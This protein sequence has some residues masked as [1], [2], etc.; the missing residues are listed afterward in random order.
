M[1]AKFQRGDKVVVKVLGN[2]IGMVDGTARAQ[3][4]RSF[5][6]VSLD[7]AKLSSYYPQEALE[8]FVAPMTVEELLRAGKFTTSGDFIQALIFRKLDKPLSDNLYT[9]YTSRTEFQ[10]HQFKPVLKFLSSSRQRLLLADEVGLGKTIEAGIILTEMSARLGGLQRVLI[11]CPSML[12]LKWEREMLRRFGLRFE[13]LSSY[14][15]RQFLDRCREYPQNAQL[16]AVV[17]LQSLRTASVLEQ[18]REVEPHFDL[19]IVDEAHHM[20]NEATLSFELGQTL[21]DFADAMLFLTA[22]PLQLGTP[23]LFNL[24]SLL[25]P[26]E[27]SDFASFATLIEP[28]EF[29]NDALRRL[30]DPSAALAKLRQVENTQQKDKFLGNAYYREALDLLSKCREMTK[31]QAIHLQR[32]L[33]ELNSLSYVFT[34][35]K[36]SDV[37]SSFPVREARTIGVQFTSAERAFYNAVTDFVSERFTSQSGTGQGISFAVIMPQRQVA[38]CIQVMKSKIVDIVEK[39]MVEIAPNEGDVIDASAD[40]PERW[41]LSQQEVAL[42]SRL[43]QVAAAVGNTDTKFDE[44][45]KALRNLSQT[46]PTAKIMVFSFFKGT[47]EYL[48]R[49]LE[50]TEYRGK[51]ALI[52]GDVPPPDRAKTIDQFR[53]SDSVQILLSSEV[54]G[55]GLDFEFCNVIFNYDLPWNPMR[56]EQRIGRLDRYGQT[57]E[58]ILIFNFSME[59]TIDAEILKRLYYR[60]K[61]FERYIGDLDAILG[62]SIPELT[63]EMFNTHL[64]YAQK[65]QLIDR[66]AENILRKKADLEAFESESQ[67]LVGQDEYFTQEVRRI[68]DSRRFITAQEVRF[69]LQWFIQTVSPGASLAPTRKERPNVFVLKADDQFR[70]LVLRGPRSEQIAALDAK[71]SRDGGLQ[72]T[73]DYQEACRDESLEFLTIHHPVIKAIKRFYDDRTQCP[74]PTARILLKSDRFPV[75]RYL[76]LIY[77]LEKMG[78]KTDLTLVPVLV[79]LSNQT[80]PKVFIRDEMCD[81]FLGSVVEAKPLPDD[82]A[83]DWGSSQLDEALREAGD[84]LDMIRSDEERDLKVFN[85]TLINNQIESIKQA[86]RLALSRADSAAEKLLDKGKTERDSIVRL[87]RGRSRNLR[88]S[89]DQRIQALEAKKEVSVA[90]NLIAGGVAEIRAR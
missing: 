82:P 4:G 15:M 6:P 59:G 10:V 77:L 52:H 67:K 8:K 85:E 14:R 1:Q 49:R 88:S 19:V 11:V 41:R 68:R 69:F 54:G 45:I 47:L 20:R 63:R 84:Y 48:R 60:I 39:R 17:S 78:L 35:T 64:T 56:I 72:V 55:E 29:I 34:R 12:T 16:Q 58:K 21:S 42:L 79:R 65:Q 43:Q 80:Q 38:S 89:L 40:V 53:H 73:F 32:L 86:T 76:F 74:S 27:F 22:T 83:G 18:I 90:F 66:A 7:L 23:D 37:E 62:D 33:V 61:I 24:L 30:A 75:G 3:G 36:K 2:K 13:T 26:E 46:D 25:I 57:H 81:W 44:F 87:Y 70:N 28:N 51:L 31:E 5:Y 71:L 50:G 9:F